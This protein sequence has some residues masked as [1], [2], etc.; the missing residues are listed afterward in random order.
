MG[1]TELSVQCGYR[2]PDGLVKGEKT[3]TYTVGRVN[4]ISGMDMNSKLSGDSLFCL[5]ATPDTKT[6]GMQNM[7][8]H[9]AQIYQLQGG[10][11]VAVEIISPNDI[12][13]VTD[14][15]Q[16]KFETLTVWIKKIDVTKP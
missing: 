2:T 8:R 6:L 5:R 14:D 15:D 3:L 7:S 13:P 10:K 11:R 1:K 4:V 16:V 12:K 9:P